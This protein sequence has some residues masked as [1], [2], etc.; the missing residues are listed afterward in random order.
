MR[1]RKEWYILKERSKNKEGMVH[2]EGG[3]CRAE[4]RREE[5][6]QWKEAGDVCGNAERK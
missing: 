6:K 4:R 1:I 3:K 5:K 2:I